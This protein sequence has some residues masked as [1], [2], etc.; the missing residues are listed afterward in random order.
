MKFVRTSISLT[1]WFGTDLR[2]IDFTEANYETARFAGTTGLENST[3][4]EAKPERMI[5]H[6]A[7]IK[8]SNFLGYLC[9]KVEFRSVDELIEDFTKA[10]VS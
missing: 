5:F 2:N 4:I 8:S 3:F 6:H 10:D 1:I 7:D 9:R